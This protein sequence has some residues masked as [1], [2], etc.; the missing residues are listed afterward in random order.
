MN[1][2]VGD[3]MN[4][5][6]TKAVNSETNKERAVMFVNQCEKLTP[7]DQYSQLRSLISNLKKEIIENTYSDSLDYI[8]IVLRGLHHIS[9]KNNALAYFYYGYFSAQKEQLMDLL[10]TKKEEQLIDNALVKDS[11]GE[12]IQYLYKNGEVKEKDIIEEL[13]IK[14]NCIEPLVTCGLVELKQE[15]FS[16]FYSLSSNGYIFYNKYLKLK[17]I[18]ETRR[19]STRQAINGIQEEN[20]KELAMRKIALNNKFQG[21]CLFEDTS[22]LTNNSDLNLMD[23]YFKDSIILIKK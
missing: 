18:L 5:I 12:I 21:R 10:E 14:K 1:C 16:D 19:E 17:S 8:N 2:L 13:H 20:K 3:I 15:C 4:L 7:D 11:S 6:Q 22:K 23:R 9:K